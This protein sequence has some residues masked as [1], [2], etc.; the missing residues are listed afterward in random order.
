MKNSPSPPLPPTPF[1]LIAAPLKHSNAG[2]TGEK[3]RTRRMHFV[4]D[5]IVLASST[6]LLY[7]RLIFPHK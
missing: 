2:F 5:F 6:A 1:I 4:F 3:S 7:S